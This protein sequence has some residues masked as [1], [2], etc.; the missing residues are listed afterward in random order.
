[1]FME[2]NP[3]NSYYCWGHIQKNISLQKL[4]AP[5]VREFLFH[6]VNIS[7]KQTTNLIRTAG[8]VP[9]GLL[10]LWF[11]SRGTSPGLNWPLSE[12]NRF[13]EKL[14]VKTQVYN[15]GKFGGLAR[16]RLCS[17]NYRCLGFPLTGLTELSWYYQ[18]F[19]LKTIKHNIKSNLNPPLQQWLPLIL[20]PMKQ[21]SRGPN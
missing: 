1:M 11:R 19:L 12:S 18:G 4:A 14:N 6:V 16:Q 3:K 20:D 2:K 21:L 15:N 7:L 8:T 10:G 5:H 9:G 17:S 13:V